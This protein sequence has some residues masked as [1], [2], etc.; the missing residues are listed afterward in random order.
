[1]YSEN[2]QQAEKRA[3]QY[4]EKENILKK[5]YYLFPVSS[6]KNILV[7]NNKK[8]TNFYF[9]SLNET[10][11]CEIVE[12]FC[13]TH[14]WRFYCYFNRHFRGCNIHLLKYKRVL[15]LSDILIG[16]A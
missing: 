16:Y 1:M 3:A 2:S 11:Q 5:I 15:V 14:E 12:F 8:N 10:V 9:H 6:D 7:R 13:Y 4:K